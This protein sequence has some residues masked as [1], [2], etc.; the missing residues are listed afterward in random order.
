M[1]WTFAKVNKIKERDLRVTAPS[2]GGYKQWNIPEKWRYWRL[3][4][5]QEAF[6]ERDLI[7]KD[8]M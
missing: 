8:L 4:F 2:D 5:W 3:V 1:H 7:G 6:R